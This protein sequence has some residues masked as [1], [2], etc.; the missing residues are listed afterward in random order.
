MPPLIRSALEA[1][2]PT[3]AEFNIAMALETEQKHLDPD[4][5]ERGVQNLL[6]QPDLGFYLIAEADQEVIGSLMITSEWSDWRNGLFWWI[7]SVYIKPEWRRKGVFVCLYEFI[8][9]RARAEPGVCGLRLYVEQENTGAQ[10]TYRK[11]GMEET[12]YRIY[13]EEL[14]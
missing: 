2:A 13:E 10:M 11:V 1:D 6:N 5:V 9:G 8:R 4:T 7:Q 3:I 12:Y 14:D